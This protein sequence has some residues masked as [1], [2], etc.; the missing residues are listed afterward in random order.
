MLFTSWSLVKLYNLKISENNLKSYKIKVFFAIYKNLKNEYNKIWGRKW[1]EPLE[2]ITNSFWVYFILR[3]K[4]RKT[5]ENGLSAE[6]ILLSMP[7][8]TAKWWRQIFQRYALKTLHIYISLHIK[9]EELCREFRGLLF[10]SNL[11]I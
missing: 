5:I 3:G 8:H 2:Q 10:C 1:G 4:M 7:N 9:K 11:L 6:C